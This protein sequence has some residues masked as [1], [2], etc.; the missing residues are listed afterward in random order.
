MLRKI[1]IDAPC[2]FWDVD[3][4][5]KLTKRWPA[6]NCKLDCTS[7]GWNPVENKRR[8]NGHWVSDGKTVRLQILRRYDESV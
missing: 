3:K 1:D 7:C 5:G 2:Y 4:R 8:L 6:V